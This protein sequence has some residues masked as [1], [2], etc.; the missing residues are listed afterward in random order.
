MKNRYSLGIEFS[1]Q[2]IKLVLL[3]IRTKQ[4]VYKSKIDY[5]TTF[6]KYKTIGGVIPSSVPE[7][8]HTSPYMLIETMDAAFTNLVNN[9]INLSQIGAIKIDAMQHCTVYTNASFR[10]K[11]SSLDP[12]KSLI[13]QLESAISRPTSPIWEDR[14]TAAET[15]ILTDLLI[16]HDGIS[17]IT[18]NKAELRFPAV[19]IMRWAKESPAEY[20]NTS[21]IFLLSAFMTSLLSGTVAPVDTGDGWGTNL[22]SLNIKK[23]GW[24]KTVLKQINLYFNKIGI[25]SS[26]ED[27]IG[28]IDHYDAKIGI[29]NPYFVKK[30]GTDPDTIILTGTG[31]N[32]AT[33]LGCGGNIVI[34]LGSSYTVN[35][36]MKKIIPSLTG[37]YNVFGYTKGTAMALS[38]ITN[39]GKVHDQFIKKYI[40]KSQNK[41]ITGA[42]WD[43]YLKIAGTTTLSTQEN[44]ML[45]YLMDESVPL[46]KAG[47]IRDGF[48]E[49][50]TEINIRALQVSQALALKIHSS[51]LSKVNK[52]CIVAGGSKNPFLRQ[53]ITDVFNA[54]T[55]TIMNSDYAA[56]L[57][58]AISAAKTL[59]KTTYTAAANKFV[60]K[61]ESSTLKPIKGNIPV[62][63]RLIER[64]TAL[65]GKHLNK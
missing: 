24:N 29:I 32:P 30:Y 44:L 1:T 37:E 3:D 20:N 55:Y 15:K 36:I 5:D 53:L 10:T 14:S 50:S 63:K 51:H 38:C 33:L 56:P 17:N 35:G 64:Y 6:P 16:S 65:E 60:Q 40:V 12:D 41:E 13:D 58:C 19:Q 23:P 42:D 8:R 46:A 62:V 45:P 4:V 43:W 2:S 21:N 26:I 61:D 28:D 48:N 9:K 47:I 52:I 59:L 27:K 22:N 39:G 49:T 34:S 18:G 31:D 11:I 25:T 57:G 54:E 7:I